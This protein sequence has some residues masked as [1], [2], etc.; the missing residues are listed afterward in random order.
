MSAVSSSANSVN[1]RN[2]GTNR[3]FSRRF[4]HGFHGFHGFRIPDPRRPPNGIGTEANE[5]NEEE[6][7]LR[8]LRS[9]L[10][11]EIR[12]I[13]TT[14]AKNHAIPRRF[15]PAEA[16]EHGETGFDRMNRMNR[17]QKWK[18]QN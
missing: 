2:L 16:R 4:Y 5:G 8:F 6:F 14:K 9:L 3:S 1:F 13:R 15:S 17:I 12:V 18:N 11:K 7:L 10:F